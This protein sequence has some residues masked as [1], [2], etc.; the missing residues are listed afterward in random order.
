MDHQASLEVPWDPELKPYSSR[1]ALYGVAV[2]LVSSAIKR[3]RQ[4]VNC[5]GM[6]TYFEPC[7]I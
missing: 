2:K 3:P 6:P 5:T 1:F 4:T 7:S